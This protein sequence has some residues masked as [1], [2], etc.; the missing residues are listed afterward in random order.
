MSFHAFEQS[1]NLRLL[2]TG[3]T[4]Q[5]LGYLPSGLLSV[6]LTSGGIVVVDEKDVEK[7]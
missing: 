2:T 4:G 3:E 1:Q 7:V 6:Q 5:L